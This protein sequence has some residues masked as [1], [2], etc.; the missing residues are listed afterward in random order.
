MVHCS[1]EEK[2]RCMSF[3]GDEI[4][5]LWCCNTNPFQKKEINLND[6]CYQYFSFLRKFLRNRI[7]WESTIG[8]ALWHTH[9]MEE[10]RK[11]FLQVRFLITCICKNNL[12][13]KF[14][15]CKSIFNYSVSWTW[16]IKCK[17]CIH[18]CLSN[19]KSNLDIATAVTAAGWELSLRSNAVC[20]VSLLRNTSWRCH[21]KPEQDTEETS[22]HV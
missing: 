20:I 14:Y 11:L 6:V 9:K 2:L 21:L 5:Q 13:I 22:L 7:I 17:F 18:T 4:F 8:R 12:F 16:C 19:R 15:L 10:I 3:E 1:S